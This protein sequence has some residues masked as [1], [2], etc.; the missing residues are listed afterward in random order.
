M[1]SAFHRILSPSSPPFLP[2]FLYPQSDYFLMWRQAGVIDEQTRVMST[3]FVIIND[4]P[5]AR[6]FSL[7]KITFSSQTNGHFE[8][9]KS[10]QTVVIPQ[11]VYGR[12]YH[13]QVLSRQDRTS[14]TD[15]GRLKP[16]NQQCLDAGCPYADYIGDG[17]C[18]P[19]C[20]IKECGYDTKG[21]P[22][23]HDKGKKSDCGGPESD[24]NSTP[25]MTQ[26]ELFDAQVFPFEGK[27]LYTLEVSCVVILVL[28]TLKQI[29]DFFSVLVS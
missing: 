29:Y 2:S 9:E 13:D 16:W 1:S 7:V 11:Y 26:T 27:T 20:N 10:M 18:D 17:L 23:E 22:K 25:N 4:Q 21:G 8:A 19:L 14:D 3:F 12:H 15:T 6:T 24:W 28:C 5:G